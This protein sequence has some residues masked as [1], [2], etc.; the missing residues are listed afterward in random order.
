MRASILSHPP[1]SIDWL[2]SPC[3]GTVHPPYLRRRHFYDIKQAYRHR[4]ASRVRYD[5]ISGRSRGGIPCVSSPA[6]STQGLAP[7]GAVVCK[8]WLHLP[9]VYPSSSPALFRPISRR[10]SNI[11]TYHQHLILGRCLY[12]AHHLDCPLLFT[13][14]EFSPSR[15]SSH[16][17][18]HRW[19]GLSSP[20]PPPPAS[21]SPSDPSPAPASRKT[22]GNV[23]SGC[24]GDAR[25]N[26]VSR[27]V[28]RLAKVQDENCAFQDTI[29]FPTAVIMA[30]ESNQRSCTV[31]ECTVWIAE[32]RE[33]VS[34]RSEF[35]LPPFLSKIILNYF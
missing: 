13:P 31:E 16:Q 20:A 9:A 1:S 29:G 6:R 27:Y 4:V 15:P 17:I 24:P 22:L 12:Q 18:Y 25:C 8:L 35:L 7:F 11:D 32:T 28:S 34:R 2:V 19:G 14:S 21:P 10:N 3:R 30:I 23:F 5:R 33:A 26:F